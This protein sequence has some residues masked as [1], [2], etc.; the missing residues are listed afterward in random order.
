M[1]YKKTGMPNGRPPSPHKRIAKAVADKNIEELLWAYIDLHSHE[2]RK[3]D[4]TTFSANH[5][6]SFVGELIKYAEKLGDDK[7]E[8]LTEI[9]TFFK[10]NKKKKAV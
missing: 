7:P 1:G 8:G 6:V 10:N 5:L 9:E 2:L 3:G 4:S